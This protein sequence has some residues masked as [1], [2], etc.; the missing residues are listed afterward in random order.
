MDISYNLLQ[1]A[2]DVLI[3]AHTVQEFKQD[4]KRRADLILEIQEYLKE[5]I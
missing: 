1:R 4:T 3:E 2:I 5:F